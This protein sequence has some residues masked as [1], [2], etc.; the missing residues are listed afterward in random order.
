MVRNIAGVLIAVGI[1]KRAPEWAREV[2]EACDRTQ[3]GVTARPD[4]LYLM[5]VEYP[6]R[7][8]LPREA[9][10]LVL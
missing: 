8:S 10:P 4:G 3:G 2:L 7:F 6:E 1:G 5:G 9:R